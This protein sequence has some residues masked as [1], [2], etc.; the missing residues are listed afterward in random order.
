ML[1]SHSPQK[2]FGKGTAP[3]PSGIPPEHLRTTPMAA[4]NRM[5]SALVSLTRVVN[6]M[7]AGACPDP[8]VPFLCGARLHAALKK[9]QTIRPIA[10]GDLIRRLVAKCM[11]FSLAEGAAAVL[12]PHQMG[13]GVRNGCEA[14]VHSVRKAMEKDP[15]KMLLQLDLINAFNTADRGTA[16]QEIANHFPEALA[17]VKICYAASSQLLFGNKVILSGCRFHQ[18]DPLAALL[19]ALVLMG[20]IHIISEQVLGLDVN[21]WYLDDGDLVGT[22]EQLKQVVDILNREGPPRGLVLSIQDVI[23]P[24]QPKSTV[25]CPLDLHH[26][27]GDDDPLIEVFGVIEALV[28]MC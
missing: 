17:W 27:S 23:H 13:V 9:D 20:V 5:S 8:V 16:L 28:S 21:A 7:A 24:A 1:P 6:N 11:A 15:T 18:G 12:A 10:F 22:K 4:N 26:A 25:W 14:I 3:G 19:F 2:K